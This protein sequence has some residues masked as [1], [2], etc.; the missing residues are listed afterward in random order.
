LIIFAIVFSIRHHIRTF[1]RE[2]KPY[3][4]LICLKEIF[5]QKVF[6]HSAMDGNLSTRNK[7]P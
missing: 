3:L 6:P 4:F 2:K 7:S 1:V 5:Y